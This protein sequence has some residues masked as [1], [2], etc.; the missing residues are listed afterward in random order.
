MNN[1]IL[2]AIFIIGL[3]TLIRAQRG[4]NKAFDRRGIKIVRGVVWRQK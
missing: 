4:I 2:A 3:V 1:I